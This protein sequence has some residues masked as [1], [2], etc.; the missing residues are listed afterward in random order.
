MAVRPGF[1]PAPP[2]LLSPHPKV[3]MV[4]FGED[5]D[6]L[7]KCW[8]P[9]WDSSLQGE[10]LAGLSLLGSRGPGS[11]HLLSWGGPIPGGGGWAQ[12]QSFCSRELWTGLPC[13]DDRFIMGRSSGEGVGTGSPVCLYWPSPPAPRGLKQSVRGELHTH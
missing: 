8:A 7:S 12:V 5:T 13:S 6:V 2:E 9:S 11:C 10:G 4:G 1:A 3:W